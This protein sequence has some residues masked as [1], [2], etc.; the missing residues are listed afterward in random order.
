M[1]ND[2]FAP[3]D[4]ISVRSVGQRLLQ[5]GEA[6]WSPCRSLLPLALA[7]KEIADLFP[8]AVNSCSRQHRDCENSAKNGKKLITRGI[9]GANS[10]GPPVNCWGK[11]RVPFGEVVD[12]E[13]NCATM[14]LTPPRT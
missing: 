4:I 11:F 5:G 12:M 9:S 1:E 2:V 13:R 6:N 8:P 7:L 14:E 3:E 10:G